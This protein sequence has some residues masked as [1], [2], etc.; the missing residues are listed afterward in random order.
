MQHDHIPDTTLQAAILGQH[1]PAKMP[2]LRGPGLILEPIATLAKS[3]NLL[4]R[5]KRSPLSSTS[6]KQKVRLQR[7]YTMIQNWQGRRVCAFCGLHA[8]FCKLEP[9]HPYGRGGENLFKVV[10]L[11]SSHHHWV[12]AYPDRAYE[13]GWLQ[14]EYRG[15]I[16]P[17]D[18]PVPWK[19]EQ[20]ITPC[21]PAE[22]AA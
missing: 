11:C 7:Y 1:G 2:P 8:D 6:A 3:G 22:P 15:T 5:M 9:H 10:L 19:P 21:P 17:P 14:P 16:R 4:Y 20:L 13:L 18:F 12:H